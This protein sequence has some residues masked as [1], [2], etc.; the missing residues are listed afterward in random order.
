MCG[1]IPREGLLDGEKTSAALYRGRP[2]G[3]PEHTGCPELSR[4]GPV[5]AG[6][7]IG[8]GEESKRMS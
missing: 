8:L 2:P 1:V 5:R 3:P 6:D 7:V 4:K